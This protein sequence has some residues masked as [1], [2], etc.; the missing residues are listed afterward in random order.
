MF[1]NIILK[2]LLVAIGYRNILFPEY[3]TS[4]IYYFNLLFLHDE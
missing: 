2:L 1:I 3:N 4:F